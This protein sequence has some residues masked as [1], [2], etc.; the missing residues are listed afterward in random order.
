[1]SDVA[2]ELQWRLG[3]FKDLHSNSHSP[4]LWNI[5]NFDNFGDFAYPWSLFPLYQRHKGPSCWMYRF[6]SLWDPPVKCR[7][8]SWDTKALAIDGRCFCSNDVTSGE[9]FLVQVRK[10]STK[11]CTCSLAWLADHSVE[12]MRPFPWNLSTLYLKPCIWAANVRMHCVNTK[13]IWYVIQCTVKWNLPMCKTLLSV[14]ALASASKGCSSA[15]A[16][17]RRAKHIEITSKVSNC[18]WCASSWLFLQSSAFIKLCGEV[19]LGTFST[20]DQRHVPDWMISWPHDSTFFALHCLHH[21]DFSRAAFWA[22][23]RWCNRCGR[24]KLLPIDWTVLGC[25]SVL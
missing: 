24:L 2:T 15:W 23:K 7:P 11:S 20:H 4:K 9:L 3:K 14:A 16:Q 8:T 21:A 5:W 18:Y 13:S 1:M 12:Q 6:A 19:F 25:F 17:I 22:P 10:K